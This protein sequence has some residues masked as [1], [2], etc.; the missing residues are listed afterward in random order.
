MAG[1]LGACRSGSSGLYTE[2]G[3]ANNRA[4]NN[5]V[6]KNRAD[7]DRGPAMKEPRSLLIAGASSGIGEAL[8]EAYARNVQ[9]FAPQ[10]GGAKGLIPRSG[11]NDSSG[12]LAK[13]FGLARAA[14]RWGT[15]GAV[16]DAV[17]KP[18]QAAVSVAHATRR[19][20]SE[21]LDDVP[22]SP[23]ACLLPDGPP[24]RSLWVII[25]APWY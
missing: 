3:N 15:S 24:G 20:A 12:R 18:W 21:G 9:A 1:G 4:A 7:R 22:T 2:R 19:R 13:V 14:W 16:R 23:A 8:A 11:N 5:R 25:T 17:R 10:S 6:A